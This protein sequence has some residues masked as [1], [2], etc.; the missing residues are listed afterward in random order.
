MPRG[1]QRPLLS[2]YEAGQA[3]MTGRNHFVFSAIEPGNGY[4]YLQQEESLKVVWA[5][6]P[7]KKLSRAVTA[8]AAA[9]V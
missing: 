3:A 6:G 2:L 1:C 9:V 4:L 5:F 7:V 8:A